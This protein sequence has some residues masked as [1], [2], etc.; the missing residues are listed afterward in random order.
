MNDDAGAATVR[1]PTMAQWLLKPNSTWDRNLRLGVAAVLLTAIVQNVLGAVKPS[2]GVNTVVCFVIAAWIALPTLMKRRGEVLFTET[3]LLAVAYALMMAVYGLGWTK[4]VPVQEGYDAA[5]DFVGTLFFAL[6]WLVVSLHEV[7]EE[8][9]KVDLFSAVIL[10]LLSFMAAALKFV[11]DVGHADP[12][13]V[14]QTRLALNLC[15]AAVF[16]GLYSAMRRSLLPPDPLTGCIILLF[17]CGQVA[18]Y[19]R[20]CLTSVDSPCAP[21]TVR[22]VIALAI[23]WLLLLGK[24]AFGLY[25]SY[26][27]FNATYKH[28]EAPQTRPEATATPGSSSTKAG[29]Q[30]EI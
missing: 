18:I 26:V 17:G 21:S 2:N 3:L 25:I 23:A 12:S 8:N 20:D 28:F 9:R 30:P 7:D 16:F 24:I 29:A 5:T 19:G 15:N 27:Y 14:S 4:L 22:G 11:A 10:I 1:P 13:I 6:A